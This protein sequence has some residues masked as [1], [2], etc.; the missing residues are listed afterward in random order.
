MPIPFIPTIDFK[1]NP[2]GFNFFMDRAPV[3]MIRGPFGSGKT[4]TC[5]AKI[6]AIALQ[7]EP[8]PLDNVRRTRAAI[9]RNT[10]PQLLR[11]TME[12]WSGLFPEHACGAI[13]RTAPMRQTITA[14]PSDDGSEPGLYLEIDFFALDKPKD[15][16]ELLSYEGTVIY[17]NE[18]REIPKTIID[19]A[20]GRAGR[21]KQ[22]GPHGVRPSWY[23]I[24]ADTNPPD[25]NHWYYHAEAGTDPL[26]KEFVG[27]AEGWSFHVQPPAVL[28]VEQIGENEWK[29]KDQDPRYSEIVETNPDL[30]LHAASRLWIVNPLAENLPNLPVHPSIDPTLNPRGRGS[31]YGRMIQNKALDWIVVYMQGRFGYVREGKPVIPEF[32]MDI[33]VTDD[34]DFNAN[35]QVNGGL[36]I[37]GNTLQPAGVFFQRTYRGQIFVGAET[38]GDGLGV[39][40]FSQAIQAT[41]AKFFPSLDIGQCWGDPAGA[42]K[43]GIYE[44]KAFDAMNSRGIPTLPAP[45]NDITVRIDAGKAPFLRL[46]DQQP[47]IIIHRR[48]STLIDALSGK[49]HYRALQKAVQGEVMHSEAPEKNHPYSDIGD[50]Y[51]YGMSGSGETA[52]LIHSAPQHPPVTPEQPFGVTTHNLDQSPHPHHQDQQGIRANTNFDPFNV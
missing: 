40:R 36:D 5:C 45:S 14:P 3:Q 48:C 7:Q 42:T 25:I 46:V 38:V 6:M 11:T 50:A 35:Y 33:H 29:S 2:T 37:G 49:W 26:T 22:V 23:G 9:V 19:A 17:F 39:D 15:V 13:R 32:S 31:Y 47:G 4:V 18:V 28:E 8:S 21:F 10:T 34:I 41:K 20:D 43:D 51:C 1:H 30:I 24:L 52:A 16:R 12:T 44:Q 27:R